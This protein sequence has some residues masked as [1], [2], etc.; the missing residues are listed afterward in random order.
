M[1]DKKK[2]LLVVVAKLKVSL[3]GYANKY[4]KP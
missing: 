1:G 3:T 4:D 2:H